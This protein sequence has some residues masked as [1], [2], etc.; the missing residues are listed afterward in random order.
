MRRSLIL[1]LIIGFVSSYLFVPQL[2]AQDKS[3]FEIGM[4]DYE[5]AN[6]WG[7][8]HNDEKL[9][10]TYLLKAY[11]VFIN[12]VS[13]S[14]DRALIMSYTVFL[15]LRPFQLPQ[16]SSFSQ[17]GAIAI[18]KYVKK[19]FDQ[20]Y[21]TIEKIDFSSSDIAKADK[22]LLVEELNNIALSFIEKAKILIEDAKKSQSNCKYDEAAFKLDK[23]LENW[24]FPET[25][26]LLK[27]NNDLLTK[28][29]DL[30]ERYKNLIDGN[31]FDEV[32]D[33][34][35]NAKGILCDDEITSLKK[36]AEEKK[37]KQADESY[38]KALKFY[39]M[40]K[41]EEAL[42]C[43]KKSLEL[44]PQDKAT[45]LKKKIEMRLKRVAFFL[46]FGAPSAVKPVNMNY[47][48]GNSYNSG[49][50]LNRNAMVSSGFKKSISIGGGFLCLFSRT[51]GII[52]SV[53]SIQHKW[54]F[55]TDYNFSCMFSNGVNRYTQKILTDKA[56][57][58]IT[59]I[60]VDFIFVLPLFKDLNFSLQ[61]G[62]AIYFA[63]VNLYARIGYGSIWPEQ[64]AIYDDCFSLQYSI[65]KNGLGGIGGNIGG[66]LEYRLPPIGLFVNFEY[67]LFPLKKYHWKSIDQR[68][69]GLNWGLPL[70]SPLDLDLPEYEMKINFSTFKFSLGCRYYF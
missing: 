27:A 48:V 10:S 28:C 17:P 69:L 21:P 66:G 29:I 51:N 18:N 49:Q 44:L 33:L 24:A 31:K 23:S 56:E 42:S 35:E 40:I 53:S 45:K 64:D 14:D 12:L 38:E 46:D 41:L 34:L 62:P 4:E 16:I 5:N 52:F 15:R 57:S 47:S 19:E 25:A 37:K 32:V 9:E 50:T 65:I 36:K 61:V 58:S 60:S 43:V 8:R 59:P 39:K 7:G 20:K 11:D 55:D 30:R 70:G 67:Y 13:D 54:S 68:Y 22:K 2:C 6:I 63:D 3:P 26:E 1:I